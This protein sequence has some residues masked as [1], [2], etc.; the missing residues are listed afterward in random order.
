[1]FSSMSSTSSNGKS[2][3]NQNAAVANI[4]SELNFN[5]LP[6]SLRNY[7]ARLIL[8]FLLMVSLGFV[9]LGIN[10]YARNQFDS[11]LYNLKAEKEMRNYFASAKLATLMLY[12]VSNLDA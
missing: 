6:H 11:N 2:E 9:Q 7:R 1:M 12:S 5:S 4:K 8:A 3:Q 10:F